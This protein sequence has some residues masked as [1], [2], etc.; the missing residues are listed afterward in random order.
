MG[1]EPGRLSAS[2]WIQKGSVALGSSCRPK[3]D[4]IKGCA[5]VSCGPDVGH[6]RGNA[7]VRVV[8]KV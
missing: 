2:Q 5:S 6:R 3:I 7:E 1:L 8:L 4:R